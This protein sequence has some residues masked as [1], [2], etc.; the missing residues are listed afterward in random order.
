MHH[1][2][3]YVTMDF[4]L[5]EALC[6]SYNVL[7]TLLKILMPLANPANSMPRYKFEYIADGYFAVDW[8]H[9]GLHNLGFGSNLAL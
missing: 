4:E 3:E 5:Y 6:L 7:V 8:Y 9:V 2:G 1:S